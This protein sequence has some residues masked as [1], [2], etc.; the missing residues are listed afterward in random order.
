MDN[1]LGY[2]PKSLD[3]PEKFLIWELDQAVIALM[4]LVFG[5]M[6][7]Q[8]LPGLIVGCLAAWQYGRLKSGKHP[9]F[10]LHLMY[11]WLPGKILVRT[12]V[13]PP[14]DIRYFLG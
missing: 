8:L 7:G 14:S 9:R 10:A 5:I 3:S 11:W 2:I 4:L 1:E 12:R 13:T 6:A